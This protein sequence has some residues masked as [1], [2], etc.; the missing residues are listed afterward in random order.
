MFFVGVGR[1]GFQAG[2]K[3]RVIEDDQR[4]EVLKGKM[5]SLVC[6]L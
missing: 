1:L 6:R 5:Q 4:P 3:I 2:G